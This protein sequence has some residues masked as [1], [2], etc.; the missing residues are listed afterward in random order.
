MSKTRLKLFNLE[1]KQKFSSIYK[2]KSNWI[3]S[4]FKN[5]SPKWFNYRD[6]RYGDWMSTGA[7][8][9]AAAAAAEIYP[10]QQVIFF[11]I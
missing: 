3:I 11:Y 10:G 7:A 6:V 1:T 9:A 5:E 2:F 8:T 4:Q